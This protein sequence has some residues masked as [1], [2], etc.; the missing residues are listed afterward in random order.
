MRLADRVVMVTGGGNG[1]GLAICQ[2]VVHEG[3]IAVVADIDEDSARTVAADLGH[4]RAFAVAVDVASEAS[5]E[6]AFSK[7]L[8]QAGRVDV[9]VNNAGI[10]ADIPF[11]QTSPDLFQK[12][13]NVNLFG[14]FLCSKAAARQMMVQGGGRI[15]NIASI[16]GQRGNK[17]RCAYGASKGGLITFTKV[18]AAEL[19]P[20]NILVNAVA[21][22][23]VKT[24]LLAKLQDQTMLNVW[25]ER[26]ALHRLARPDE[27]AAPVVFLASSDASF[28]TG[29]VL[30]VD[31][32]VDGCGILPAMEEQARARTPS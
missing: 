22:G 4:A 6:I 7:I 19:A 26:L 12:I 8:Q 13:L 18:L 5:V 24:P 23:P 20:Y 30:N 21:P 32:G 25:T 11:L 28:I 29:H 14:A 16:S 9:L 31:G 17:G 1:I 2:R 27:I 10:A 3:G 15:I